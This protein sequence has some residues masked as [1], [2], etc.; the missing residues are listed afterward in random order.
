MKKLEEG[1]DVLNLRIRSYEEARANM[2]KSQ[3]ASD[4]SKS[5]SDALN[6]QL[7]ASLESVKAR[8]VKV[9]QIESLQS[10]EQSVKGAKT[11][12]ASAQE[13]FA[14]AQEVDL[15]KLKDGQ[16]ALAAG[17]ARLAEREK[18]LDEDRRTYKATVMKSL[19]D[20]GWKGPSAEE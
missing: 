19:L 15:K 11:A 3:K 4:D 10:L 17:K 5:T 20:A 14:K 7:N 9:G 1:L 8:E 13:R 18:K 12:L 6:A 2:M 16:D